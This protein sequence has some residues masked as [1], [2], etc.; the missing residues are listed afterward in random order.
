MRRLCLSHSWLLHSDLTD[1]F[2]IQLAHV[3]YRLYLL[4]NLIVANAVLFVCL[5]YSKCLLSVCS[6]NPYT[7]AVGWGGSI[8]NYYLE[9][10][11]RL[12]IRSLKGLFYHNIFQSGYTH[13]S[14]LFLLYSQPIVL[15][16]VT[17]LSCSKLRDKSS[18]LLSVGCTLLSLWRQPFCCVLSPLYLKIG[19][20]H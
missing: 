5:P 8:I 13:F 12:C 15:V 9:V 1:W 10:D 17:F 4:G 3:F 7:S 18:Y 6:F 19:V 2:C 11:Q 14:Y 20:P 16:S